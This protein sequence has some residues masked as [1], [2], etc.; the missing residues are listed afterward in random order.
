VGRG[1][2]HHH[3]EAA[4]GF[5]NLNTGLLDHLWQARLHATHGVLDINRSLRRVSTRR[6]GSGD[7]H[8]ARGIRRGLKIEQTVD[9]VQLLLDRVRYALVDV[10]GGGTRIVRVDGNLR[11]RHVWIL[12]DRQE[13]DGE[14]AR[15]HYKEHHHPR[16]DGP[17]DEKQ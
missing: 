17:A 1:Q 7:R 6:E 11:R 8:H 4:T 3:Q 13:W 10:F 9:A 15:Q 5:L 2:G 12:R 14:D 16:K